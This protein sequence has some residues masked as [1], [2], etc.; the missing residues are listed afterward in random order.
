M[1]DRRGHS[2]LPF[3][4]RAEVRVCRPLRGD[5]LQCDRAIEPELGGSI[6]DTHPAAPGYCFD[7]AAR[8]SRVQNQIH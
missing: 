3:E 8:E 6:D 2:G 1:F 4:P 5:E 7:A